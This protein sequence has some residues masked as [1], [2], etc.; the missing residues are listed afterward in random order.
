MSGSLTCTRH[1]QKPG[2]QRYTQSVYNALLTSHPTIND[3]VP[4]LSLLLQFQESGNDYDLS[5]F[6]PSMLLNSKVCNYT[7]NSFFFF[8]L[9][10]IVHCARYY[11]HQC[12]LGVGKSAGTVT[13]VCGCTGILTYFD[14]LACCSRV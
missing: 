3:A 6:T 11:Y 5:F 4:L 12:C 8:P 2:A 13:A 14:E 1:I 7:L 9:E 10:K